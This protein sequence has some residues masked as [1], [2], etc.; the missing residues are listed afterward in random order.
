MSIKC[1]FGFHNY[2]ELKRENYLDTSYTEE[3]EKGWVMCRF[4]YKCTECNK[5]NIDLV[6]GH[7][8]D[9]DEKNG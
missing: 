5:R 2:K 8:E 3:G 6:Q 9:L 1:F 7:W 4:Y